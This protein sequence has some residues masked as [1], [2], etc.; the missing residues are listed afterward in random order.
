MSKL[1]SEF[2]DRRDGIGAGVGDAVGEILVAL[3]AQLGGLLH[4]VHALLQQLGLLGPSWPAAA[5]SISVELHRALL[6]FARQLDLV[7]FVLELLDLL[8][9]RVL[10]ALAVG[11]FD[12]VGQRAD[13]AAHLLKG[14]V[15]RQDLGHQISLTSLS[16][17]GGLRQGG[18]LGGLHFARPAAGIRATL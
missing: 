12:L 7:D 1:E 3:G 15:E 13:V 4:H 5:A 6:G 10:A 17:A 8:A 16:M 9:Q 2:C 14:I 11:D 18:L